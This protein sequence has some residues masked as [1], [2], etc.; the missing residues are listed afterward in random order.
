MVKKNMRCRLLK[1]SVVL[2]A[3]AGL[4]ACAHM[5]IPVPNDDRYAPVQPTVL[6][7]PPL[8]DGSIYQENYASDLWQDQRARRVGDILTI[9]LQES[10][11][12][13]KSNATTLKKDSSTQIPAA[14][15][16]G[17]TPSLKADALFPSSSNLSLTTDADAGREFTG[18]AEADQSNSLSG[19]I[20]VTVAKVLPNGLLVVRGEKWLTLSRG[21]EFIRITG[22]VRPGDIRPDNSILSTKIADARIAYSGTGELAEANQAGWLYRFFNHPLWPF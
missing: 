13:S 3:C 21:E 5:P 15:V 6:V 16:L 10:T 9:V 17:T 19:N 20:T 18:E 2:G 12:S 1:M 11:S 4:F 14:T 22:L 7:P 8:N